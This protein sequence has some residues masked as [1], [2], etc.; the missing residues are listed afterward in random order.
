MGL[1]TIWQ[2]FAVSGY[3]FWVWVKSE[4]N[5]HPFLALGVLIVVISAWVLYKSEVRTK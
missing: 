2:Q 5:S 3:Q 1:E 4:T